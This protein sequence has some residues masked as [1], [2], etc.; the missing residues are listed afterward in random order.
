[1][2]D[3]S[4]ISQT[5]IRIEAEL[6]ALPAKDRRALVKELWAIERRKDVEKML[7]ADID[8]ED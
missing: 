1:M 3:E 2:S 8:T 6:A 4:L 5:R 7:R